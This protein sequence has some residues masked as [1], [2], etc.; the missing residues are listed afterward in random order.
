MNE[1]IKKLKESF[2]KPIKDKILKVYEEIKT[3]RD[4]IQAMLEDCEGMETIKKTML[5]DLFV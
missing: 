2:E 3:K 1:F 5:S 4:T